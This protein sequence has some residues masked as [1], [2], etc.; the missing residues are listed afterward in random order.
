M[1]LA[2][3]RRIHKSSNFGNIPISQQNYIPQN[4]TTT[5]STANPLAKIK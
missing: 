5:Q 3:L 2:Q 4:T 1:R